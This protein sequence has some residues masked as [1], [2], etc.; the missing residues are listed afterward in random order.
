MAN[1]NI[2]FEIILLL[3]FTFIIGIEEFDDYPQIK[4]F[5]KKKSFYK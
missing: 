1:A 3:L 2:F 4:E 5:E